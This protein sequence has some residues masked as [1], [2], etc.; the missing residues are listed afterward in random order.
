ML[1]T[2]S[3]EGVFLDDAEVLSHLRLLFPAGADTTMLALGNTLSALLTHPDQ[4]ALL[5]SDPR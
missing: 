2:E 5:E 4:L 3:S 1:V